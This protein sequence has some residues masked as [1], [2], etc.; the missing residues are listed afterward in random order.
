M[1]TQH[2]HGPPGILLMSGPGIRH[3]RVL[4]NAHVLDLVPTILHILGYPVAADFDGHVLSEAFDRGWLDTAPIRTIDS[5][6]V[7]ADPVEDDDL[8]PDLNA[9]ELERLRNMGYIL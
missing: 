6:E 7:F 5:Y 3:G 4:E 9:E 2:R 1:Y 8:P